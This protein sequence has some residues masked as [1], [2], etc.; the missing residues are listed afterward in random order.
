MD[1]VFGPWSREHADANVDR[2]ERD[3]TIRPDPQGEEAA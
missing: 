1:K 3:S 2:V